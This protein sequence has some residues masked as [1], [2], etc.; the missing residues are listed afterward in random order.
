MWFWPWEHIEIKVLDALGPPTLYLGCVVSPNAHADLEA[1]NA[2]LFGNRIFVVW[3]VKIKVRSHWARLS[4]HPMTDVL[5][6][7]HGEGFPGGLVVKNPPPRC[8]GCGF[9]LWSGNWE[10][11]GQEATRPRSHTYWACALKPE[12]KLLEAK[13]PCSAAGEPHSERPVGCNKG[14]HVQTKRNKT[15]I[16]L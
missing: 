16:A 13:S 2:V 5:I 10:P 12:P 15:N 1:Q 8:R 4:L 7:R 14:A 11:T 6:R 9:L 3:L